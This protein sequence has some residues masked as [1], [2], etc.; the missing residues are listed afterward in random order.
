[1]SEIRWCAWLKSGFFFAFLEMKFCQCDVITVCHDVM[2]SF[3][4]ERS[5][6]LPC[7]IALFN[8]FYK[9]GDVK[10]N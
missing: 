3:D 8:S 5:E 10:L 2:T 9:E 4:L 6:A 1:M 7:R